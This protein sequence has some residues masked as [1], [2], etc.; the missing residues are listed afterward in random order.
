MRLRQEPTPNLYKIETKNKMKMKLKIILIAFLAIVSF[1]SL[2]Q[3]IEIAYDYDEAGNRIKREYKVIPVA[4]VVETESES[5]SD[6]EAT[7]AGTVATIEVY[8]DLVATKQFNIYPNP[9]RGKLRIDMLNYSRNT[10]GS[11][12]IFDL[13]GRLVG[14]IKNLSSSMELDITNEP[15]GSYIIAIIVDNEKSEWQIVKQ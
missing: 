10:Q 2:A 15:A 3:T 13:S 14:Q 1:N 9:T 6:K 11:I 5:T 12:Q 7:E 4:P 8:N